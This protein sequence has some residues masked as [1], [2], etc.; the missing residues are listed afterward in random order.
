[1][2]D[3]RLCRP[4]GILLSILVTYGGS[5]EMQISRQKPDGDFWTG[6]IQGE[7]AM[8]QQSSHRQK[9]KPSIS[10]PAFL[11]D[12]AAVTAFSVVP[13]H[14]LGGAGFVARSAKV[15]VA[16]I[17]TGGQDIVNMRQPIA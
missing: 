16:I 6:P 8:R 12:A 7:P 14:V 1:M 9:N 4:S 10:R 2:G 13:R 15:N 11:Q 5:G 17:G 3:E